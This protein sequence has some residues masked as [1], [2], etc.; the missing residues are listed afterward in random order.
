[1]DYSSAKQHECASR[2]DT[3]DNANRLMAN[4]DCNEVFE[5]FRHLQALNLEMT[6]VQEVLDPLGVA[7]ICL[8]RCTLG[9]H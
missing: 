7:K 3:H 6:R 8:P 2:R 1:M 9:L 5:R 4:L